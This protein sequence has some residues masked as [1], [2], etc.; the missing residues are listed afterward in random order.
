MTCASLCVSRSDLCA[1]CLLCRFVECKPDVLRLCLQ[2]D[3]HL[4]STCHPAWLLSMLPSESLLKVQLTLQDTRATGKSSNRWLR[5]W[6][7]RQMASGM[8][9]CSHG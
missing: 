4:V 1:Y 9:Q 3:D 8:I 7:L 5:R 2:P 6:S